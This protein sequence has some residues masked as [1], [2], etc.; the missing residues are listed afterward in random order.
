MFTYIFPAVTIPILFTWLSKYIDK[1]F[2]KPKNHKFAFGLVGTA[3]A[4]A[5]TYVFEIVFSPI[6]ARSYEFVMHLALLWILSL[7][8]ATDLYAYVVPFYLMFSSNAIGF[9]MA[10]VY[11]VFYIK[12]G[13]STYLLHCILPPIVV[14][15]LFFAFNEI[16]RRILG[17]SI[18]GADIFLLATIAFVKGWIVLAVLFA[19]LVFATIHGM[20]TMVG[21]RNYFPLLPSIFFAYVLVVVLENMVLNNYFI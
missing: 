19:F 9:V 8:I 4:I 1:K 2:G 18:G 20:V 6:D 15:V 14:F 3:L 21:K 12:S 16:G 11:H 7:A 10:T 5:F 13:L 17:H